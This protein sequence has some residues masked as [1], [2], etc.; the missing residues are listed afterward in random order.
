MH[1]VW[2][3]SDNQEDAP[4]WLKNAGIREGIRNQ[5]K[6]DRSREELTRLKNE[7]N[8]MLRWYYHQLLLL[9]IS[10]CLPKARG[11]FFKGAPV[12]DLYSS[13]L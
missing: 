3:S 2:V 9:Q 10:L 6:Q 11:E 1:D 8:N 7:A 4:E 13:S 5:L 12:P